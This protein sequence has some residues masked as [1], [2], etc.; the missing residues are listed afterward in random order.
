M[1][2]TENPPALPDGY[3]SISGPFPLLPH[4]TLWWVSLVKFAARGAEAQEA[5]ILIYSSQDVAKTFWYPEEA[6]EA[7]AILKDLEPQLVEHFSKQVWRTQ[8]ENVEPV[9]RHATTIPDFN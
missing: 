4:S 8:E 7:L 3:E 5:G 6:L 1:S 9:E 2:I